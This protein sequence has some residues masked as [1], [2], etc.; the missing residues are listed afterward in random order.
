MEMVRKKGCTYVLGQG[1]EVRDLTK[2]VRLFLLQ[3]DD[4]VNFSVIYGFVL[5]YLIPAL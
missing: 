2:K 4:S 1:C 3:Y 5:Y